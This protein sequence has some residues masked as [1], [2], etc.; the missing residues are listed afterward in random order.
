MEDMPRI[1][2]CNVADLKEWCD[3]LGDVPVQEL[4]AVLRR[5]V[6]VEVKEQIVPKALQKEFLGKRRESCYDKM[7]AAAAQQGMH[8]PAKEDVQFKPMVLC[9]SGWKPSPL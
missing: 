5:C 7:A 8:V 1:Q 3:G 6:F 9:P 4:N 2:S